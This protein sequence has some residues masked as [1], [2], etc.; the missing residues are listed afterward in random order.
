MALLYLFFSKIANLILLYHGE[1]ATSFFNTLTRRTA[2]V[3]K[4][5]LRYA[6]IAAI[7][8]ENG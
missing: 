6:P 2:N 4:L 5:A 3:A 1:A 7:G 8:A